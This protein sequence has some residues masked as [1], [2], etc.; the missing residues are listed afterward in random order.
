K[1]GL[2]LIE[3][4]ITT[5]ITALMLL[6]LGNEKICAYS[7]MGNVK[8]AA[9]YQAA[10]SLIKKLNEILGLKVEVAP[11]L[12]EAKKTEQE[13]IGQ[14]KKLQKTTDSTDKFE[15]QSPI[16]TPMYT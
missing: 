14:L 3:N 4:G 12:K 11:L 5:G 13:I 15:P 1:H 9:D 7:I 10:V 6:D 8:T 2:E 16:R